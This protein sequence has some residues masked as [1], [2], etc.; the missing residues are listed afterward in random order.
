ML[1]LV[2]A[3]VAVILFTL[4]AIPNFNSRGVNLIAAGLACF[5]GSFLVDLL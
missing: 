2:L 4:A 3:L 1:K 5:A